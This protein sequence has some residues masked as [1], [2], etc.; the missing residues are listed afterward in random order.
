MV[1]YK[2]DKCGE[3]VNQDVLVSTELADFMADLCPSCR[4]ILNS[5]IKE[6]KREF[7]YRKEV[8]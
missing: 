6:T 8:K 4:K 5:M 7:F 2:C 1:I 3:S